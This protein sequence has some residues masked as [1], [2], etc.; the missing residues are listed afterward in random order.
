MYQANRKQSPIWVQECDFE[1]ALCPP[2]KSLSK[3]R[4]TE[5]ERIERSIDRSRRGRAEETRAEVMGVF[6]ERERERDD[7]KWWTG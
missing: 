5:R 6:R 3:E 2:S 7:S 4:E 1:F